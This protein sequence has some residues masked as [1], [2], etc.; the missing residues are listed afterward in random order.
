MWLGSGHSWKNPGL[1]PDATVDF[2]AT[3]L[4]FFLHLGLLFHEGEQG[5]ITEKALV[6]FSSFNKHAQ[7]SVKCS[8]K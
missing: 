7:R 6:H 8:G 3:V 5:D 4:V 2:T 1:N